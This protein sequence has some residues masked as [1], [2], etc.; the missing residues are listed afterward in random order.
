MDWQRIFTFSVVV[1]CMETTLLAEMVYWTDKDQSQV[2]RANRDGSDAEKLLDASDGVSDPRGIAL[3]ATN[4]KMY[5]AENGGNRIRRANLDGSEIETIV[6]SELSFPA[7]I[8]LDLDAGKIYWA[9]R[10]LD[11]IRRADLDGTNVETVVSVPAGGND[12]APYYL[13][14]DLQSDQVYWTDFD[15]RTI[16]RASLTDGTPETFLTVD[17]PARLRDL[18]VDSVGETIYWADR[19]SA[20]KIQLAKLD[21]SDVVTLFD[22]SDGLGRP[23]GLAFD[24]SN[25]Q[26]YWT[27]TDTGDVVR[28]SVAGMQRPQIIRNGA[29]NID[30]PW[31]VA[32]QLPIAIDGDFNSDGQLDVTDIN[33][34]N[35]AV[36]DMNHAAEFD[37]NGD[38]QVD[39][40]DLT[41]WVRDLKGTWFG[42]ADLNGEF[43]SSDL[44]SIFREGKYDFDVDAGWQQGD[45]NGDLRFDSSDLVQAFRDGGYE[46][47]PRRPNNVPEPSSLLLVCLAI[48][49]IFRRR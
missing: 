44:V 34:L 3:D 9:D 8:E 47:G 39:A 12:D 49:G 14:L 5:W 15:S 2:W 41:V 33:M 37:L 30:G 20:P 24:S 36:H 4:G 23:H 13:A 25:E 28:G 22:S 10:N 31:S 17:S 35:A 1:F 16:H 26:I 18:V 48:G 43:N 6:S 45:W 7:D 32:L 27:D 11:W 40:A 19:S 42:D 21:G 38:K 29:S 46:Q